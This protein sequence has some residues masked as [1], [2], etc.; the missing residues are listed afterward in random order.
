METIKCN[1]Y[2]IKSVESSKELGHKIL[3]NRRVWEDIA[4]RM[5][6]SYYEPVL[7]DKAETWIRTKGDI[8]R[9]SWDKILEKYSSWMT[10]VQS[11]VGPKIFLS[12]TTSRSAPGSTQP[13]IHWIQRALIS[14]HDTANSPFS[15]KFKNVWCHT[16]TPLYT[17]IP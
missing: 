14:G 4:R 16:S 11:L 8:S 7:M 9:G 5:F 13:P 3:T 12:T 17:F 15:A 10:R 2:G 6:E 1:N